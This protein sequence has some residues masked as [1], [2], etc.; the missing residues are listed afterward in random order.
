MKIPSVLGKI[1][2]IMKTML[3]NEAKKMNPKNIIELHKEKEEQL[4]K[5][6]EIAK[7]SLESSNSLT[8]NILNSI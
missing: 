6:I 5:L 2:P 7:K 1:K 4:M 3:S 8:K